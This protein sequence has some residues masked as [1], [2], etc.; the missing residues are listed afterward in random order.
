MKLLRTVPLP[1]DVSVHVVGS[2]SCRECDSLGFGVSG[3]SGS[4]DLAPSLQTVGTG[5][6][7]IVP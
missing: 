1:L 3:L 6:F 5:R 2:T 4:W 7:S